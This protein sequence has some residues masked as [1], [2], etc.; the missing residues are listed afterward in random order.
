MTPQRAFQPQQLPSARQ[1]AIASAIAV[2]VAAIVLVTAVFPA[3]YGFD[4]LGTGRALGLTAMSAPAAM[5]AEDVAPSGGDAT[6][7][8][9]QDGAVTYYPGQYRFDSREFTLGPYEYVEY[10][11]HLEKGASML[12]AW[13]ASADVIHD[14]HGDADGAPSG[15]PESFDKRPRRQANGGFVAPFSGIHG[16]FWENP[17]GE[18]IEI[19]IASSGFYAS[20][21]EFRYDG[22]RY[23][24]EVTALQTAAA[25]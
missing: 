16:W 22:T 15:A 5:A 19:T 2:L 14:F 25:R 24:H 8:P 10:K 4:P 7:V 3:E 17:G 21:L 12:F 9:V 6:L 23:P 18:T 13:T 20:A 1:L 11:Y